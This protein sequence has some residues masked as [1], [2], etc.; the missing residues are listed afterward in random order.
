MPDSDPD[1]A[2]RVKRIIVLISGSLSFGFFALLAW[3]IFAETIPPIFSSGLV[4]RG[5]AVPQAALDQGILV[6]TGSSATLLS[7]PSLIVDR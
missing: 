3:V 4:P 2:L 7:F 5:V 6:M 1:E